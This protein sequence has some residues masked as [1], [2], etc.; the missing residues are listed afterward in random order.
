MTYIPYNSHMPKKVLLLTVDAA[1]LEHIDTFRHRYRFPSRS[2]AMKFLL[3][4]ALKLKPKPQAED[5]QE[6]RRSRAQAQK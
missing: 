6:R 1:L 4:S 3:R 2:G 5:L